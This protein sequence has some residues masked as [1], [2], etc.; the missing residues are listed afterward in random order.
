MV[1]NGIK[2]NY[3]A[4]MDDI[5]ANGASK[6]IW[7]ST[8]RKYCNACRTPSISEYG[9]VA[10][11]NIQHRSSILPRVSYC[12][13]KFQINANVTFIF[14]WQNNYC[15][16]I[17]LILYRN[18]QNSDV[19]GAVE[20]S[21]ISGCLRKDSTRIVC[22]NCRKEVFT[23][24]EGKI[25]GS[26]IMWV[27]CCFCFG[28]LIVAILLLCDDGIREFTHYCPSCNAMA[29]KY[30]PSFSGGV[31]CFFILITVGIIAL[32]IWLFLKFIMPFIHLSSAVADNMHHIMKIHSY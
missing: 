17:L 24:V 4:E 2:T 7:I 16:N 12:Q 1:R 28:N 26:G 25:T 32:D 3:D 6:S 20:T 29:G 31:I 9:P 22:S 18:G 14:P 27:I 23:R 11:Y 5:S 19:I 30:S 10:T 21:N 13:V 15:I 8:P